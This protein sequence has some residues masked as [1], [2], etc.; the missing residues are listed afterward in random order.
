MD[1]LPK[2][3]SEPEEELINA[4]LQKA[5]KT[6]EVLSA[7]LASLNIPDVVAKAKELSD[8]FQ[9]MEYSDMINDMRTRTNISRASIQDVRRDTLDEPTI[10]ALEEI[11]QGFDTLLTRIEGLRACVDEWVE[12]MKHG[13]IETKDGTAPAA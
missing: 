13:T 3:E 9:V 7:G 8:F 10:K 2:P 5:R 6:C 11:E 1:Q 4:S 12:S